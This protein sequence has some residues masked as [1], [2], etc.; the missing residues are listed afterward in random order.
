MSMGTPATINQ[1]VELD[2]AV[3]VAEHFGMKAE[4]VAER[5]E[6]ELIESALDD[7]ALCVPRPPVVTIMGHVDHG[8]T[9]LLDAIRSARV[10][11][12]EAGGITQHIGDGRRQ[13]GHVPRHPGARGVYQ[14]AG[15]RRAGDRSG[16]S[17]RRRRRWRDAADGGGD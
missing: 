11:E 14:H 9:S 2:A 15:A 13:I 10:T 12:Q 5:T 4:G 17:G 6:E 1:A 3:L 7:P 16:D 8:K